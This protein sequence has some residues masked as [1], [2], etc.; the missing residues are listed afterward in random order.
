MSETSQ[1]SG[2]RGDTTTLGRS[3]LPAPFRTPAGESFL[4]ALGVAV[5]HLVVRVSPYLAAG[6]FHDDGVYL[7]VGKSLAEGEGYRS[8]YA[9][10]E[11]VHIKYPPALPVIHALLWRLLPDLE[12]VHQA[13]LLLS[14]LVTAAAAGVIWWIAR[15][16]IG[17]SKPVAIFFV[18]GPFLLEASVQYF[19]LATS[20]PWFLLL[21]AVALAAFAN[22]EPS[23]AEV[24]SQAS[25]LE[26][27]RWKRNL[28][29]GAVLAAG[30]LFR[31]Q[32]IVL[33]PAFWAAAW[34]RRWSRRSA[35][36]LVA[37]SSL[38]LLVWKLWH[39]TA[40]RAGPLG[41]QPDEG[42]Y[43]SW[44][45]TGS[46]TDALGWLVD[47]VGYQLRTYG[48]YMPLHLSGNWA[49]GLVLWLTFLAMVTR[50]II[51]G[52]R[53]H[54]EL[55]LTAGASVTAVALWP[56][57]Q[58]RFVLALLPFLALIAGLATQT[59]LARAR[60]RVRRAA[61]VLLAA[62]AALVT[63]RQ[64]EIRATAF[65]PEQSTEL[66]FHPS[67]DYVLAAH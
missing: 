66:F 11:P 24:S 59:W 49:L 8:L 32:S 43:G 45:L 25:R 50:G 31:T 2:G 17:L 22:V 3:R 40:L 46:A 67:G 36:L 62:V 64:V 34:L 39:R 38:P 5:V 57:W 9:V 15:N 54:P 26:I 14:L 19:N 52:W 47:L 4:V 41:T 60:P 7:A 42:A 56:W 63:L 1:N 23:E 29:V 13:A 61:Y 33:L 20:E 10:G 16:R 65:P 53:R 30:A 27:D 35:V 18:G 58:D 55:V 48:A 28:A 12:T 44:L 37:S 21:W 51:L 6:A